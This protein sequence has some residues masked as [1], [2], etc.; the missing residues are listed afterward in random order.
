MGAKG[1]AQEERLD[2][3]GKGRG[4]SSER[5]KGEERE[6]TRA[7][8]E[9]WRGCSG[10]DKGAAGK[11]GASANSANNTQLAALAAAR[12]ELQKGKAGAVQPPVRATPSKPAPAMQ[13][14]APF[15]LPRLALL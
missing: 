14:L 13:A 6:G 15:G 1:R 8:G 11:K 5:E 9:Q 10:V 7:E 12:A 4:M 2:E 3:R